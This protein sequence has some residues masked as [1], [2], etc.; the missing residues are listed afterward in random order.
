MGILSWD[1]YKTLRNS[2]S[3]YQKNGLF[4]LVSPL[5]YFQEVS[6]KDK[7][8]AAQY[9]IPFVGSATNV[10]LEGAFVDMV[11]RAQ[12]KYFLFA[13]QDFELIHSQEETRR[14]LQDCV[15]LLEE[16]GVDYV[17]LR[18]KANPGEPLHSK[19]F[20]EKDLARFKLEAT[21]F[22]PDVLQKYPGVFR[23][24]Q[25]NHLWYIC[26]DEHNVWSNNIFIAKTQWLR[27]KVLPVLQSIQGRDTMM[28]NKLMNHLKGYTLASGPGLFKHNRLD[29]G[30]E[31]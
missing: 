21:H 24:A 15:K 8:I 11:Q 31:I 14:V 19:G 6:E 7:G 18:D 4:S 13:E 20:N 9:G 5:L 2:L 27:E 25:Y 12:T 23:T 22:V 30:E 3:S 16:Q 10:G 29:R 26:G 17:R 1:A 28:E